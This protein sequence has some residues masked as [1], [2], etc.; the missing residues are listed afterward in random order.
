MIGP[1]F[2]SMV[3]ELPAKTVAIWQLEKFKTCDDM[4]FLQRRHDDEEFRGVILS[5][6]D[7]ERLLESL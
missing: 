2:L 7:L 1:G 4:Y 3:K 6:K 5:T